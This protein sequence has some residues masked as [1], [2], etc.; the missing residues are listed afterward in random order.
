MPPYH[1]EELLG[2][3]IKSVCASLAALIVVSA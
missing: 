1:S 3:V 2:M